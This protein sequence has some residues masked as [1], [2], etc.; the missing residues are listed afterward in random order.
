MQCD[1]QHELISSYSLWHFPLIKTNDII[2]TH[3]S[4][5]ERTAYLSAIC[6]PHLW[7]VWKQCLQCAFVKC[8]PVRW[9]DKLTDCSLKQWRDGIK[10]NKIW[11]S[12][13]KKERKKLTQK[14]IQLQQQFYK[15]VLLFHLHIQALKC[16]HMEQVTVNY[17]CVIS[18][19][20]QL[21]LTDLQHQIFVEWAKLLH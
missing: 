21:Q 2:A 11:A 6:C 5:Y 12:L 14:K 20:N 16:F 17:N 1:L 10:E 15:H 3:T 18:G 8:A 4:A 7:S 13:K 19:V 9:N